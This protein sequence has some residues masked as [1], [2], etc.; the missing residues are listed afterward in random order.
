VPIAAPP[1]FG[2]KTIAAHGNSDGSITA[3]VQAFGTGT[4]QLAIGARN[5]VSIG[6]GETKEVTVTADEVKL[7]FHLTD[8]D[9]NLEICQAA[10][11]APEPKF[12][13]DCSHPTANQDGT[14]HVDITV[15]TGQDS[16]NVTAE[17]TAIDLNCPD[18]TASYCFLDSTG[19]RHERQMASLTLAQLTAGTNGLD[20]AASHPTTDGDHFR[21]LMVRL[22][23]GTGSPITSCF[24]PLTEAEVA[25]YQLD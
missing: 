8:C 19:E 1:A 24:V 2:V 5:L 12:R 16:S 7:L 6:E 15:P 13:L 20:F 9:S 14:L 22:V 18:G 4:H 17:L 10:Q 3:S 25:T 23:D 11:V 21:T